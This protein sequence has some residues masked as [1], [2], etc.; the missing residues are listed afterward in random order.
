MKCLP[1]IKLCCENWGSRLLISFYKRFSAT[2][3]GR[4]YKFYIQ[5][6]LT[7]RT[8]G[9]LIFDPPKP[10]SGCYTADCKYANGK[11]KK[12]HIENIFYT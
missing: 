5:I 3:R 6:K 1:L 8:P 12:Q 4:V 11:H 2:V 7:L 9:T 10:T